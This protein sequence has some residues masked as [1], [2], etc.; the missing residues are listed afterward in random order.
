MEGLG[1]PKKFIGWIMTCVQTVNYSIMLNGESV[2]P[3]NAAIGRRQGDLIS[4][5][6]FAIAMEYL[7]RL[8]NGLKK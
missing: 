6:L 4:P 5:F 1:F 7:S 8:L 2:E 3:F